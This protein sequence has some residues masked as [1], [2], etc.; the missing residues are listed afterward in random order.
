MSQPLAA[1]AV[2]NASRLDRARLRRDLALG[3]VDWRTVIGD[4]PACVGDMLL[5]EVLLNLIPGIQ[6][7][8]LE[9]LGRRAFEEGLTLT[10]R[11]R[12]ASVRTR[13]WVIDEAA[14]LVDAGMGRAAGRR[15]AR[16][17]AAARR[18]GKTNAVLLP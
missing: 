11:A 10:V 3:R 12:R 8:S 15:R 13:L 7:A 4:P 9:M 5:S 6:R 14:P 18:K 17:H 1:L 16:P 2:G